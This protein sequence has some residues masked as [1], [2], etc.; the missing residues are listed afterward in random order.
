MSCPDFTGSW[1]RH[2]LAMR[3]TAED[4]APAKSPQSGTPTILSFMRLSTSAI[5]ENE[6]LIDA[7]ADF[8][9]SGEVTKPPLKMGDDILGGDS[10]PSGDQGAGDEDDMFSLEY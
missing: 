7:M 5:K 8:S 3:P 9:L 1:K 6:P 2:R 10:S 4:A